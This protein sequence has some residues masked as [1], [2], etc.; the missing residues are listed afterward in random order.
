M[1]GMARLEV[2]RLKVAWLEDFMLGIARLEVARL[3]V[4]WLEEVML[5]IARLEE[6]APSSCQPD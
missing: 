1:L 4:A 3:N 5:G 2:A 6:V